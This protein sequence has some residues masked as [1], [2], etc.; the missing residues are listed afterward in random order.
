MP[1]GLI[2]LWNKFTWRHHQIFYENQMGGIEFK[3]TGDWVFHSWN[4]E[5]WAKKEEII[6]AGLSLLI[7]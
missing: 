2:A 1:L 6:A 7:V 5:I 4:V 3:K